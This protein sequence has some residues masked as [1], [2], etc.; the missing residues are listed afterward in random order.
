MP[1]INRSSAGPATSF[2]FSTVAGI[3]GPAGPP[4]PA[5]TPGAPGAAGPSNFKSVFN[6]KQYGATGNGQRVGDASITVGT[7]LLTSSTATFTANDVGKLCTLYALGYGMPVE[8]G[9][10]TSFV[11]AH[12]VY[13]SFT[14]AVGIASAG[15]FYWGTDDTSAILAT[16][17]AAKAGGNN[18]NNPEIFFPAGLYCV[19]QGFTIDYTFDGQNFTG[20]SYNSQ[21]GAAEGG[22]GTPNNVSM[23]LLMRP[24]AYLIQ[25]TT[26][27][28]T[29]SKLF[30]N[31]NHLA[32][33]VMQ[34]AWLA[35]GGLGADTQTFDW[36]R[37]SGATPSGNIHN[38]TVLTEDL[39]IDFI[40]FNDCFLSGDFDDGAYTVGNIIYN[41][42]AQAF[43]IDY[44][45]GEMTGA[46]HIMNFTNQ[47]S[48]N[49]YGTQMFVWGECAIKCN[50]AQS[51]FQVCD[52]YNERDSAPFLK[53]VGQENINTTQV[54]S[55]KNCHLAFV[56]LYTSHVAP[57]VVENTNFG[58][59]LTSDPLSGITTT[60]GGGT[61]DN[62]LQP[63]VLNNVTLVQGAYILYLPDPPNL[64]IP[65]KASLVIQNP[66]FST[67]SNP[68]TATDGA[69]SLGGDVLACA[70]STP[71]TQF[72][73]GKAV[74][75][76]GAGAGGA[77]L[78]S[79][80]V[81]YT[82][83]GH[84]TLHDQAST[85]VT[86]GSVYVSPT[87]PLTASGYQYDNTITRSPGEQ[88][89]LYTLNYDVDGYYLGCGSC[90][91]GTGV[92]IITADYHT[93]PTLTANRSYIISNMNA[94]LGMRMRFT[95]AAGTDG[96]VVTLNYG[97]VTP[98][99]SVQLMAGQTIEFE[100][101]Y[102]S[103]W[104][105]VHLNSV[106]QVGTIQLVGGVGTVNTGI[107]VTAH[108]QVFLTPI[109]RAGTLTT[110]QMYSCL[111]ANYT[112]GGPGTG[113]I[114]IAA[115][116]NDGTTN[117]LDTST[118]AYQILG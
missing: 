73:V 101:I 112:V 93:I 96:Y 105:I 89:S 32:G 13:V 18:N 61:Q 109:V 116:K 55:I 9:T 91:V 94:A 45:R 20:A 79:W 31:G 97:T 48:N 82:N 98:N 57:I 64:P 42:T 44:Y 103:G 78:Y 15:Q 110:T 23:L 77:D 53:L 33:D 95:R 59:T 25:N 88:V 39:E 35:A 83:T 114:V 4:G 26:I 75:V 71:F 7:N 117:T 100:Y 21:A 92:P 19:T 17:T 1:L 60:A 6:P 106:Q 80:I 8:Y 34:F 36:C 24:A 67:G 85:V 58:G 69:M 38:Y 74:K 43:L 72:S 87:G 84:V 16:F 81:G 115:T 102:N 2:R 14:E 86:G 62:A 63:L 30:F 3:P 27:G 65:G 49:I 107:T 22:Y 5:G 10:I 47:G 29:W 111:P 99:S 11:N 104:T 113:T 37:F 46:N 54:I 41:S 50:G 40:R 90:P 66:V 108:S 28:V 12:E 56:G 70:T 52:V 68:V 118:I 51:S 76:T